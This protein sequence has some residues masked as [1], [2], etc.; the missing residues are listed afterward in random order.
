MPTPRRA[1]P[2]WRPS[3]SGLLAPVLDGGPTSGP[4]RVEL[5]DPRHDRPRLAT[6]GIK[7]GRPVLLLVGGADGLS[8]SQLARIGA[9]PRGGGPGCRARPGCR[10]RRRWLRRGGHACRRPR[11]A[12]DPMPAAA[13]RRHGPRHHRHGRWRRSPAR[14]DVDRAP[15]A[16]PHPSRRRAGRS[17][18]RRAPLAARRRG[19]HVAAAVRVP[20][21]SSTAGRWPVAR[22][23]RRPPTVSRCW[24]SGAVAGWRTSSRTRS[25]GGSRSR[26]GWRRPRGADPGRGR[27]GRRPSVRGCVG[28]CTPRWRGVMADVFV[29][30]SR[31]D[32]DFVR[33][34]HAALVGRGPRGVG[35]LGGHPPVGQVDGR[36]PLGHRRRRRVRVRGVAPTARPRRCAATRPSTRSRWASGSCPWSGATRPSTTCPRR[37]APTTG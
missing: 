26:S 37:S 25:T 16:Q 15:G 28:P 17:M 30:Y 19:G 36:G 7:A 3:P 35:R 9:A 32:Q 23:S 11:V 4:E 27:G 5:D 24:C 8:E 1:R 34:L 29:S 12:D 18:G 31:R 22:R 20:C 21:C 33:R 14:R 13:R 6:A 2:G 10:D